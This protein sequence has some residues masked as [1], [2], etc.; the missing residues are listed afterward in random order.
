MLLLGLGY[1][2]GASYLEKYI[3]VTDVLEYIEG[4]GPLA[5]L[6]FI[7]AYAFL[8][9]LPAS[10]LTVAGGAMFGPVWGCIYSLCGATIA[11]IYPFWITRWLGKKPLQYLLSKTGNFESRFEKFQCNVEN[12]GWKY[13]MFT[14]LVPLFPFALQ[15]YFYGLTRISFWKYLIASVI[16]IIPAAAT[17]TYIGYAGSEAAIGAEGLYFKVAIALCALGL[18]AFIPKLISKIKGEKANPCDLDDE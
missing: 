18:L 4:A 12:Q 6:V 9:V 10:A 15:N 2:F 17:Y 1:Y 5:P 16:F 13:V 7:I 8:P 3:S 11:M 14:R